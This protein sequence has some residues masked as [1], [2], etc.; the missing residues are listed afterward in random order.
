ME[1]KIISVKKLVIA[2]VEYEK[3]EKYESKKTINK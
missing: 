3:T 2:E 1:N